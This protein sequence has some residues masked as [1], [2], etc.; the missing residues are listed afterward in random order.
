MTERLSFITPNWPA[1]ANIKCL[2]T[3]RTGGVSQGPFESFN[4]GVH[5]GD[6]IAHVTANRARLTEY[7]PSEPMWLNQIH[8]TQVAQSSQYTSVCDADASMAQQP[9]EVCVV[10]TADCLPVLFCNSK[11]TQVAAAHAGWRGLLDGVLENT[12]SAFNH[13]S[14]VMAW[15]GP[16]I[17]PNAF[18]VGQEVKDGFCAQNGACESCFKP[19]INSGKW[20]A[21]LYSLARLRL[22]AIG[23]SDVY[24]GDFCTYTDQARFFSYRRDGVTGRMASC[25][26]LTD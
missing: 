20:L 5:V 9:N 15:L 8:G 10:M 7:L 6:E 1:P 21:D 13:S 2:N 25:I 3:M 16:A 24:G 19:S 11:G 18:E 17:G 4:L 22:A 26:W 12:V 14:D 23:V